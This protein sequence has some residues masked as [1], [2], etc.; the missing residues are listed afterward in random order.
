M[1][2]KYDAWMR[3]SPT[4]ELTQLP[5]RGRAG[6]HYVTVNVGFPLEMERGGKE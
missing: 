2:I 3:V 1:S 6:P 4:H 5:R